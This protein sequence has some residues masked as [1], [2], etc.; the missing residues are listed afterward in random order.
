TGFS[1][2]PADHAANLSALIDG[3]GL[4]DITLVVHD[5]GGPI[6]LS[7]AINNPGNVKRIVVLNTWMWSLQD[8][9]GIVLPVRFLSSPLGKF[10]CLRF[11][12]EVEVIM[13]GAFG[14]QQKFTKPNRDQYR[15]A[16]QTTEARNAVWIFARELLGSTAFYNEL[17]AKREAIQDIPALLA[18]GMKDPLFKPPYLERWQSVFTNGQTY[19]FE[20]SG[21]FVQE[22]MGEALVPVVRDFLT[23]S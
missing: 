11:N 23:S 1:Y 17:W 20:E 8:D 18:W 12:L 15:G 7:Y 14:D 10:L 5:F 3:L 9:N 13:P 6:G 22:E 19:R 21:H 4:K 16:Q 2:L